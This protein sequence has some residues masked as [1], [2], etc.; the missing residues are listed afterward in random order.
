MNEII[1][2]D[3]YLSDRDSI[4]VKMCNCKMK[5]LQLKSVDRIFSLAAPG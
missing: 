5:E 2:I 3:E 4:V 1:K